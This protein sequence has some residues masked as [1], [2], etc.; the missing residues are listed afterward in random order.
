MISCDVYLLKQLLLKGKLFGF[1]CIA[2]T[3]GCFDN[4]FTEAIGIQLK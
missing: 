1:G 3:A 4:L 2:K